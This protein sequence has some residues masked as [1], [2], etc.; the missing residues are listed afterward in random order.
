MST[1]STGSTGPTGATGPIAYYIFDG[2]A[3]NTV[4]SN[5][6]AFNFGGVG[7]TGTTGP[8]GQQLNGANI[9]M[10]LRH[11]TAVEWT[12]S[13]PLLAVGELGYETNT[14]L[15]KIGDGTTRW[16]LLPYGGLVGSTGPT[17][18]TGHTGR[19]GW[20]GFTGPVGVTGVTG[21]TGRTG[22][23]GFGST[24]V[25]GPTGPASGGG[26]G[27]G[28][29]GATGYTGIGYTGQTGTTGATGPTGQVVYSSVVFDGGS[30]TGTYAFG[31]AFDCG[32]AI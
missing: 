31:P 23:T 20:T 32:T 10:Q 8:S 11:G 17:G 4:F 25:T 21:P 7:S 13:N 12:T 30:A 3:P 26:G 28:Y 22:P 19:T 24:G 2:G 14:G 5:G 15:F 16:I 29:T 27:T 6:P 18:Y 1:G 9:V